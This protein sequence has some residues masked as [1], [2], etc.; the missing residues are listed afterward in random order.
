[1]GNVLVVGRFFSQ[2][3]GRCRACTGALIESTPGLACQ[4]HVHL[5]R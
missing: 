1:M 3:V 2:R 4:Y 5:S